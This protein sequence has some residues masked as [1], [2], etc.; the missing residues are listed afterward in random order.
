MSDFS[1]ARTPRSK[2]KTLYLNL[3]KE[4]KNSVHYCML[5]MLEY[6]VYTH[7]FKK[8]KISMCAVLYCSLNVFCHSS[9][10]CL[11]LKTFQLC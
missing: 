1:A 9:V 11:N 7:Y 8:G 3:F 5:T 4:I 6:A 2:I 10:L